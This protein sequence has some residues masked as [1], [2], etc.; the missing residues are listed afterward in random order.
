[1]KRLILFFI[2]IILVSGCAMYQVK[3]EFLPDNIFVCNMPTLRVKLSPD[4]EY[5]GVYDKKLEAKSTTDPDIMQTNATHEY[6][7]WQNKD[8]SKLITIQ[9]STLKDPRWHWSGSGFSR[10][11]RK[12]YKVETLG[13]D[14]WNTLIRHNWKF[15]PVHYKK[16]L[17]VDSTIDKEYP[18]VKQ[19]AR[20]GI[21]SNMMV[22]I[23]YLS[24]TTENFTPETDITFIK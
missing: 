13:G 5:T 24:K 9:L 11:F 18:D 6:F 12:Q 7:V 20:M 14:K 23:Y 2:I 19:Y 17:S 8:K 3:R 16:M 21:N 22:K 4:F 1:M 15:N 10:K